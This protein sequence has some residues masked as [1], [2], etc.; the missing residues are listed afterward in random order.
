MK[1]QALS[2]FLCLISLTFVIGQKADMDPH[3]ISISLTHLPAN[4]ISPE[5]RTYSVTSY[6]NYRYTGKH[7]DDQ[8]NLYGWERVE[9]DA[10]I[11][12]K[13]N[14]MNFV[15][16]RGTSQSSKVENKDKDGKVTS[17]TYSYWYTAE[18]S[19]NGNLYIYGP[20]NE[21]PIAT[22]KSDKP[23]EMTKKEKE[24]SNNPFLKSVDTKDAITRRDDTNMS[25]GSTLPLAYSSSLSQTFSYSTA[26][27]AKTTDAYKEFSSNIDRVT[28]DH[29][30]SFLKGINSSVNNNINAL[31]GYTPVTQGYVKF[32]KLD[33]DKHP[34]HNMYKNATEALKTIFAKMRYNRDTKEIEQDLEPIIDYFNSVVE[35][36][37]DKDDK[38]QRRLKAATMYNL[39]RTYQY[40][41][42]HDKA[43]LI[44]KQ[45]ITQKLEEG[46]AEDIIKECEEIKR[47]LAFHNMA[48]R[49]IIPQNAD[50]EKDETGEVQGG[51]GK[52]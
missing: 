45:M 28:A 47:Q 40:L 35:K 49:H 48:S 36:Y 46:D 29:E 11:Q 34:E 21:L 24:A 30:D 14:V 44:A 8:I 4:Y 20:K 5:K 38:G 43:I 32:K 7:N 18:N 26:K 23:K 12:I 31:Y 3:Y 6:G 37:D 51:V 39:A 1:N 42:Q 13:P 41:D 16:G 22:K 27:H 15:A 33:T 9:K 19:G 25:G 2:I 17:T 50:Q 10:T 52:P